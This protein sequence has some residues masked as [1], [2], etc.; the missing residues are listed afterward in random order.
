MEYIKTFIQTIEILPNQIFCLCD[1][2]TR[3]NMSI[4]GGF[5]FFLLICSL[6]SKLLSQHS[7]FILWRLS[8]VT[9]KLRKQNLPFATKISIAEPSARLSGWQFSARL[10]SFL[11]S[12]PITFH[13][14]IMSRLWGLRIN[15][16]DD[17]R[18]KEL[19]ICYTNIDILNC[20]WK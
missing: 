4:K 8:T 2:F 18:D 6:H 19:L 7:K 10:C 9:Y 11:L 1:L 15:F 17:F 12:N 13:P 16:P 3:N 14:I 5:F 20:N